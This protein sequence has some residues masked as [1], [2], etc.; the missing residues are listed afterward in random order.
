MAKPSTARSVLSD[1]DQALASAIFADAEQQARPYTS[2]WTAPW[3]LVPL[4][5]EIWRFRAGPTSSDSERKR[6]S[7]DWR[8]TLADGSLLTDNPNRRMFE[9]VAK[10][11]FLMRQLPKFGVGNNSSLVGELYRLVTIVRWMYVHATVYKPA[12]ETFMRIEEGGLKEFAACISEGGVPW[13]LGYPTKLLAYLYREALSQDVPTSVLADPFCVPKDHCERITSWLERERMFRANAYGRGEYLDR[14]KIAAALGCDVQ[15]I[16]SHWKFAALLRQFEPNVT[17]LLL[18]GREQRREHPSHKTPILTDAQSKPM[19]SARAA[20]YLRTLQNLFGVRRHLPQFI[21]DT[22]TIHFECISQIFKRQGRASGHTQWIPLKMALHYTREALRWVHV[23]G[24]AIV[25][26]YIDAVREISRLGYFQVDGIRGYPSRRRDQIVNGL[27]RREEL[28]PLNIDGWTP[29]FSLNATN[30]QEFRSAPSLNDALAV[31]VGA[32]L[33]VFGFL[34]PIRQ[35]ELQELRK[36]CVRFKHGDGYWVRHVLA[37]AGTDDVRPEI[38]R[39]IPRIAAKALLLIERLSAGLQDLLG[40]TD[41]PNDLLFLLPERDTGDDPRLSPLSFVR[42]NGYL[43]RFVDYIDAPLDAYGRRWYVRIH[44]ER[45]SFLLTFFWCFRFASLDAARW[46]A[47]HTD[48]A[49][50]YAYIEANFPGEELPRIEAEYASRQLWSFCNGDP[51][52]TDNIENLYS[53]VC[54]RFNVS[55]INLIGEGDLLE[56]LHMAFVQG[57]Y[58]I[59]VYSIRNREDATETHI[60]F[61]IA[62]GAPHA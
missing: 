39:P 30:Y 49:H 17:T 40:Q 61:R 38:E 19:V 7:F 36:G 33:V 55:S 28:A 14:G 52:E 51:V 31:F 11:A 24:E 23:Y 59:E 29:K 16:K 35:M 41:A 2:D 57:T 44:E 47:G 9:A 22:S 53:A 20:Q 26:L 10:C 13:A 4:L 60:C 50:I 58:R 32:V 43:D 62:K 42:I 21:P 3:L 34:K 56:W 45:K 5:S 6:C 1:N 37:K 25:D 12:T 15:T 18:L 48:A 27:P 8:I 46:I 54:Q